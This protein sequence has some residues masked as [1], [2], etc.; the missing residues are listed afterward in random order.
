MSIKIRFFASLADKLGMETASCAA[1]EES[2]AKTV[3]QAVVETPPDE[4]TKVAVNQV[5]AN[6]DTAVTDGDE[7]AFF[8]PVTGG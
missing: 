5:Y 1:S 4:H 6:W 3:W 7:V 2:T 8:P